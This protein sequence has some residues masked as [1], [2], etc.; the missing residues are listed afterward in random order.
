MRYTLL[1]LLAAAG[2]AIATP[3]SAQ[4]WGHRH[5]GWGHH[6][7]GWGGP[8][9]G[10]YLGGP[11]YYGAGRCVRERIVRHRPNGTR[12]VRWVSRCY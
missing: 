3:A 8:R 1:G 9:V 10:V 6:H 11:T 12:V 2:L 5:G 4:H 7:G